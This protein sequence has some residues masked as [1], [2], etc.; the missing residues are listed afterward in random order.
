MTTI[1]AIVF[2]SYLVPEPQAAD[3]AWQSFPVVTPFDGAGP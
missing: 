1:S 3:Y 2:S